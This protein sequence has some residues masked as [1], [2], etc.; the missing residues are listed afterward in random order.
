MKSKGSIEVSWE[1]GQFL[2]SLREGQR[3][4]RVACIEEAPAWKACALSQGR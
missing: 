3:D 2:A 4:K 1:W